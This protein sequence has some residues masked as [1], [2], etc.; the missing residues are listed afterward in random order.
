MI[1]ASRRHILKSK[2]YV[3]DMPMQQYAAVCTSAYA[4]TS[5]AV[6]L[7]LQSVAF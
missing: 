4:A 2:N 3:F 6:A 5:I 7:D 1:R